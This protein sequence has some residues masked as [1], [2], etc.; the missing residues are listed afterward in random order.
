M[1]GLCHWCW[2][3]AKKVTVR[4]DGRAICEDC[5]EQRK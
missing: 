4:P 1:M 3:S 5:Q 2:S